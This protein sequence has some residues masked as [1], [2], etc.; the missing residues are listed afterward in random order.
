MP[1]FLSKIDVTN[2]LAFRDYNVL[3]RLECGI[4]LVGSEVKSIR[5]G[6]TNMRHSYAQFRGNELYVLGLNIARYDESG[7]TGHEPQRPRKLLAH[8][9]ELIKLKSKS[10]E[11]GLTIIP[12]RLYLT[13]G[14]IKVEVGLCQGKREYDKRE[15][16]K[17]R[18]IELEQRRRFS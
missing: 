2:K 5:R 14:R 15:V 16:I 11:K 8:K 13:K 3:E 18:E 17:K 12:L 6:G 9:H 10:S 7:K 1:E 4:A